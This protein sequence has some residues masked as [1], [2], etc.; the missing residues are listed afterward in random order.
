MIT[1][2]QVRVLAAHEGDPVVSSIYLDVDG[3]HRP[4]RADVGAAFERLAD[5]LRRHVDAEGDDR[6][7]RAV[8][9]DIERMGDWLAGQWD[10][11][12]TRGLAMFACS[13]QGWLEVVRLARPVGDAAGL[14]PRPRVAQLFAF[15]GQHQRLL[16]ALVDRRRLRVLRV[17]LGEVTEET[18]LTDFEPRAVD[19]DVELGSFEHHSE[20]AVRVHLRRSAERVAR[21]LADWPT[22]WLIVGGP[23]EAVAG[24]EGYLSVSARQR[25]AG[26]VSVRV[27][28]PVAEVVDTALEVEESLER[29]HQT[30][31]VEELEQ[32]TAS[33]RGGVIGLEA[34]LAA[35]EQRRVGTL[36]VAEGFAGPGGRCPS[37][38]YLGADVCR[39]P[40]CGTANGELDD[41][42]EVAVGEAAAQNATIVVSPPGALANCPEAPFD[43]RTTRPGRS[44]FSTGACGTPRANLP[45]SHPFGDHLDGP[46]WALLGADAT[47]FAEVV[48]ELVWR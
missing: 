11:T 28:A 12:A 37:C 32:R 8:E 46:A 9:A 7:G 4:V 24:L 2:A 45:V 16:V 43:R 3:R 29:R 15:L 33:G 10:R 31:T 20:E 36:V 34:T 18:G 19:T 13:G 5:S 1:E 40:R 14:G 17:E 47:A 26:R 38:G 25:L 39:C 48:V 27:A 22:G 41:V 30:D 23:D 6:L 21:A 35:L 44:P 42:V